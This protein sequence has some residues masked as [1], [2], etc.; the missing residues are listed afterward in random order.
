MTALLYMAVAT[1]RWTVLGL[2]QA[3][4]D[5]SMHVIDNSGVI[6]CPEMPYSNSCVTKVSP[7]VKFFSGLPPLV[8]D[9]MTLF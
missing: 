9:M 2:Q 4:H 5:V 3:R 8:Y 1:F 7:V 6:I